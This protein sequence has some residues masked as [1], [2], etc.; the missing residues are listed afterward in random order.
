MFTELCK[1]QRAIYC[2]V[3]GIRALE[4]IK[5]AFKPGSGTSELWD[6]GKSTQLL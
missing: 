5:N 4:S 3:M 1:W 2:A 6:P